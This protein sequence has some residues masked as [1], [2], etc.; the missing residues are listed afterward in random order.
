MSIAPLIFTAQL[1][2]GNTA[3][4]RHPT[5]VAWRIEDHGSPADFVGTS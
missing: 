3:C 4:V 2:T 5:E 1:G